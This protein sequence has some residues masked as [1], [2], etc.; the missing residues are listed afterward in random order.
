MSF[1]PDRPFN[2]LPALP[3]VRDIE[4]KAVLKACIEARAALAEL[5][6]SGQIIP[7]Q[8]VL[9]NSIPL[10]EAQ[11]SSEIENIVTTTDRLFRFANDAGGQADPATKEAL[12]YRTAL[13]RGFGMLRQRPLSTAIAVEVCRTIKGVELDIRNTPG[14]ALM[15]D[16]TGAVIYTPPEGE[17]LLRAK[18][19][20]WERY[21]HEAEDT[22]PLI[23]LAV[24]HYQFEAIH[25]FVDG[26]GRTGRVLNLLYLVDKGLLD[27]PVLYLSRH[28]IQNK[29]LYYRYLLEVTTHGAWE[30]WLLFMIE[31]VRATALWTTARI[32]TIR[33]LLEQTAARMRQKLPKVYS[34]ELAELIFVNPYCRISDL[35]DSGVAKRQTAAVY[36]KAM[37]SEGL[38]EEVKAGRENLYINPALLTLLSERGQANA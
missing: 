10:L 33:N 6:I 24:M 12:R 8:A 36:L 34:H 20:N 32:Q 28:I 25:P 26:N 37:V 14:T 31:A 16:A 22:D 30:Q 4:T 1:R 15:N 29:A 3:P 2:D 19:A 23:R 7:N 35:V 13:N 5:R 11:A 38:L 18:L 27:I 9:I 21:I 17:D